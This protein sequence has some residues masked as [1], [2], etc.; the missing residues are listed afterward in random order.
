MVTQPRSFQ[1]QGARRH[2]CHGQR[3]RQWRLRNRHRCD[4][5][6]VLHSA[7]QL[8]LSDHAHPLHPNYRVLAR[9]FTPPV[10]RLAF[11]YDLARRARKLRSVQHVAQELRSARQ[12][13]HFEREVLLHR[14]SMLLRLVLGTRLSL[15]RAERIQLDLLDCTPKRRC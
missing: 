9:W 15:H 6:S 4:P 8:Q 5:E 3:R 1:H 11:E 2:Y 12:R 7:A 14:A 13:A 10:P